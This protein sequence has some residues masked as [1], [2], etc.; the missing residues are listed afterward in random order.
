MQG[1]HF[2]AAADQSVS[3][4]AAPVTSALAFFFWAVSANCLSNVV[5]AH[6]RVQSFNCSIQVVCRTL[7]RSVFSFAWLQNDSPL[8]KSYTY[9]PWYAYQ[10]TQ[11]QSSSARCAALQPLLLLFFQLR[12]SLSTMSVPSAR[13]AAL[14][15][16]YFSYFAFNFVAWRRRR[17]LQLVAILFINVSL[18]V[19][20]SS[21]LCYSVCEHSNIHTQ[22]HEH[23]HSHTHT[24]CASCQTRL[25]LYC[26][27]RFLFVCG[28]APDLCQL[29]YIRSACTDL[30]VCLLFLLSFTL[31]LWLLLLLLLLLLL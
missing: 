26:R 31:S 16:Y 9:A 6:V 13:P 1:G 20:S 29:E 28:F 17:S 14:R 23:S 19:V 15:K 25:K 2:A 21:A 22:G 8:H 18:E 3:P 4:Q 24:V 7:R 10:C 27:C 12:V 30:L 5:F 11:C